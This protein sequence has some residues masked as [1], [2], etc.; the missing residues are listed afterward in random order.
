VRADL[1]FDPDRRLDINLFP[2]H[3]PDDKA[4]AIAERSTAALGV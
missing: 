1:K 4:K 2:E 3:L